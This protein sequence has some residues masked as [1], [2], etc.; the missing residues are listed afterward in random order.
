MKFFTMKK[1]FLFLITGLVCTIGMTSCDNGYGKEPGD[2]P[3]TDITSNK[4]SIS[5]NVRHGSVA[6]RVTLDPVP[7][8]ATDVDFKWETQ[9]ANVATAAPGTILGEGYVTVLKA[10]TTVVTIRSGQVSKNIQVEGYIQV[11]PLT[12]IRLTV[13]DYEFGVDS[14]L[15]LPVGDIVTVIALPYPINANT[16]T[17]DNVTLVWNSSNENVAKVDP[18][19]GEVTVTGAGKSVITI[20]CVEYDNISVRFTVEGIKTDD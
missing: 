9:D 16:L 4:V 12:G 1:V 17:S 13:V 14:T 3:L 7:A 2:V 10:G 20:S 15:V 8:N 18:I 19:T 6:V 5:E 11:E